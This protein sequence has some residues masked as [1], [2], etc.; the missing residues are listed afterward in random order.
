MVLANAHEGDDGK[1]EKIVVVEEGIQ[2]Y[3]T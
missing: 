2:A 3:K 1:A